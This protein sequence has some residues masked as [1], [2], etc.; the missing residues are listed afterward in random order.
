MNPEALTRRAEEALRGR[1][2]VVGPDG[3]RH[4]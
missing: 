2:L 4:P 1:F 3:S